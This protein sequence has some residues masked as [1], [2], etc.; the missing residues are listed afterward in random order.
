M[1]MGRRYVMSVCVTLTT[2]IVCI[3]LSG[4]FTTRA[5]LDSI[6]LVRRRRSST[7]STRSHTHTKDSR[8][9]PPSRP[10]HS[11]LSLAEWGYGI[12]VA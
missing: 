9:H 7:S 2:S 8:I 10:P 4:L 11:L 3:A 12:I 6:D 1:R 5:V